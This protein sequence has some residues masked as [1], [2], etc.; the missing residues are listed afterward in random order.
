M[1]E[2]FRRA[3]RS[4]VEIGKELAFISKCIE[5]IQLPHNATAATATIRAREARTAAM[6][7]SR[8]FGYVAYILMGLD[9]QE[10]E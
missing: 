6:R 4:L 5:D 1:S 7:M 3:T 9:E 10:T 8:Q 2:N